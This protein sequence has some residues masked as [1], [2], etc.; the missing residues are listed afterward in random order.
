MKIWIDLTNSP[1]I[2]F[3]KPFIKELQSEGHEIII[4]CR[5][6][7]NTID[8]IKQ[9]NYDFTEIG[10]HGGKNTIKKIVYFLKRVWL[11]WNFLRN[12]KP[13]LAISHSGFNSPLASFLLR[14]P[15]IYI[16]D[17]EHAKA[18]YLAFKFA[19]VILLP[20]FLSNKAIALNWHKKYNIKFYPGIKEGVYLSKEDFSSIKISNKKRPTIFI[21]PEPWTAQY[22]KAGNFFFDDL[23]NELSESYVIKI[24]PRGK[25]QGQHYKTSSFNNIYVIDKPLLLKDI[26]NDCDLFIGAGGTMTREIAYTGIPTISIYQD[27]LLEVDKYL[28]ANNFMYHY[29]NL[30]KSD[31]IQII[32][33]KKNSHNNIL[34]NKGIEAYQFIRK[35][36]FENSKQCVT[37]NY[38]N[39]I[40]VVL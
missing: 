10:G 34:K 22:Y 33:T 9:N 12:S 17:N 16:N 8:L 40:G 7:A 29:T 26:I 36:I 1:H 28:I 32:N 2:N 39:I 14:I 20:E 37:K 31:V 35:T 21:R 18:N 5:D 27:A 6:L 25:D 24:L 11:L 30:K 13:D 19:T 15:S 23:L 3:F 38:K 4:T